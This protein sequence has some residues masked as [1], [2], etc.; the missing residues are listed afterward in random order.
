M[1]AINNILVTIKDNPIKEARDAETI[2]HCNNPAMIANHNVVVQASHL[3]SLQPARC[4][5]VVLGA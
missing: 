5:L 3:C 2:S 4:V 1:G